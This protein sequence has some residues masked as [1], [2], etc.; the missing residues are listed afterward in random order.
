MKKIIRKIFLTAFGSMILFGCT[1]EPIETPSSTTNT[2]VA[3]SEANQMT[4]KGAEGSMEFAPQTPNPYTIQNMQAAFME[5]ERANAIDCKSSFFNIRTTH[6]YIRFEPQDK[7]QYGLLIQDTSLVLFDY[8]LDRKIIKGGTYYRDPSLKDGQQDYHWACVPANKILSSRVPYTVVADLYLPEQDPNLVEYYQTEY[9]QCIAVLIDQAMK[10]TGNI[11]TTDY[12]GSVTGGVVSFRRPS[13]WTPKG[14]I[15]LSDNELNNITGLDGAKV[16]V[17]RW[18]EVRE[19]L[20]NSNGDYNILHEFR[21]PV[22]YSI[23]WERNDFQLRSGRYG[24]AYFN[25]PYLR[26]DWNLDIVSGVSWHYGQIHR[27]A[28]DYYY[29][30]SFNLRRPPL[31]G[32]LG[33][34][35]HSRI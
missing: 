24:Q 18:F 2:P 6:K 14:R 7:I 17:H 31:N 35:Y 21:Y 11:D 30:N 26:G 9:D 33:S 19:A 27:G 8:P 10:R 23:K 13:K 25:G 3:L 15:R 4:G 20:T 34:S 22:N 5:L 29:N 32:F 16:R 28:F 12:S 1:K